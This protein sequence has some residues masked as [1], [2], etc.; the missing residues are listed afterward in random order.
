MICQLTGEFVRLVSQR[1][2]VRSRS[3]AS[4]PIGFNTHVFSESVSITG[5]I[6]PFSLLSVATDIE[7]VTWAM[8]QPVGHTMISIDSI[9][10]PR[11]RTIVIVS[12]HSFSVASTS[13]V[14]VDSMKPATMSMRFR[15]SLG[16]SWH[17]N[18]CFQNQLVVSTYFLLH[19]NTTLA[20]SQAM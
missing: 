19:R 18:S 10:N 5:L 2:R 13:S 8:S 9:E 16:C 7:F 4:Y 3:G 12:S 15:K 6:Y 14:S 17:S 11:A 1:R 20:V